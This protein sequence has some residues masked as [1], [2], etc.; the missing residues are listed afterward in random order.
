VSLQGEN[1]KL[2]GPGHDPFVTA[3]GSPGT[4]FWRAIQHGN[5]IV[6]ES[7]AREFRR[8]HLR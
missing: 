4:V 6:A 2:A 3:E 1:G 7:V 5:V 8:F